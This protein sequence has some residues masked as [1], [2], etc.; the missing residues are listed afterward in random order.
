MARSVLGQGDVRAAI[1]I[2]VKRPLTLAACE[3]AIGES[4]WAWKGRCFEIA[5][6]IVDAGLVHGTAVYGHWLGPVSQQSMFYTPWG[7]FVQHGWIVLAD[8]ATVIDP[9][10]WAFEAVPPYLFKGALGDEYDEGGNQWRALMRGPCPPSNPS[11]SR[12]VPTKIMKARTWRFVRA[13]LELDRT[14]RVLS[15]QQLYDLATAPL[16]DLGA[17]A[18][19]VFSALKALHLSAFIPID[20]AR[21]VLSGRWK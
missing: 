19:D 1:K 16:V 17:H 6:K 21:R 15:I 10:R 20:N 18:F 5:S 12:K 11:R 3:E 4:A 9:T 14:T 2:R 13:Y 7:G 8:D